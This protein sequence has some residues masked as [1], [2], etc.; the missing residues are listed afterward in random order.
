MA[1][2]KKN[3]YTKSRTR[4]SEREWRTLNA[5]FKT[6]EPPAQNELYA[7]GDHYTLAGMLQ[8][9]GFRPNGD[10]FEVYELAEAILLAGWD[11]DGRKKW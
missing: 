3:L 7:S 5:F 6:I 2:T 8:N 4:I 11:G 9:I 1:D 10:A